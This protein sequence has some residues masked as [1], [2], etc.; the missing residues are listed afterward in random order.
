MERDA[1][2]DE[3]EVPGP[4]E[5]AG[6][7]L[8]R[9]AELLGQREESGLVVDTEPDA[10]GACS[11]SLTSSASE[12]KAKRYRPAAWAAAMSTGS[13]TGL[14]KSTALAVTPAAMAMVSS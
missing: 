14:L 1:V 12:L 13:L 7:F 4:L 11:A 5:Q 6:G 9:R 3:T 8:D 2:G 10:P